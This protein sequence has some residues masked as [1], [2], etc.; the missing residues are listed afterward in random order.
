MTDAP[1]LPA[2]DSSESSPPPSLYLSASDL[3]KFGLH[4]CK[5]GD[6]YTA[7]ISFRVSSASEPSGDADPSKM[8]EVTEMTD[9]VPTGS[10]ELAGDET[11]EGTEG[12]PPPPKDL[13][14]PP[15]DT[16]DQESVLGFKM[17]EKKPGIAVDHKKLRSVY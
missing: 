5:V 2:S 13:N 12:N 8:V 10:A 17:P 15:A 7:T 6:I 16:D 3:D 14:P 11:E 9:V 1:I 4:D